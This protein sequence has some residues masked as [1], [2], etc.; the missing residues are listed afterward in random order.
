VR[1]QSLLIYPNFIRANQ[2][3]IDFFLISLTD[4]R[5]YRSLCAVKVLLAP[6]G[7]EVLI[8]SRGRQFSCPC[9]TVDP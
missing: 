2:R 7:A 9:V 6:H 5:L 4:F 1:D 3:F 8:G